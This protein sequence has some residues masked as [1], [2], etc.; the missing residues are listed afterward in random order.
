MITVPN[1]FRAEIDGEEV[2]VT[3][4]DQIPA[5]RADEW[6]KRGLIV[7]EAKAKKEAKK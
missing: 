1:P 3:S 5:A 7:I 2:L 6:Q 4:P